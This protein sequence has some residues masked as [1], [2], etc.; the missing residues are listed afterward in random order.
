MHA[1]SIL[2]PRPALPL[3][4]TPTTRSRPAPFSPAPTTHRTSTDSWTSANSSTV[5]ELAVPWSADDERFLTRT[6]DHLPAHLTTPFLGPVPPGNLLHRIARGV[7]DA[8][9]GD[10]KNTWPHSVRATRVKLMQLAR[11]RAL[12]DEPDSPGQVL[13]QST[14]ANPHTQHRKGRL[15]RQNSMDFM[16]PA[17]SKLDRDLRSNDTIAKL[18]SRLQKHERTLLHPHPYQY[19][20]SLTPS[21]PSSSTLNSRRGLGIGASPYARLSASSAS[22]FGSPITAPRRPSSLRRASTVTLNSTSEMDVDIRHSAE[23]TSEK[24]RGKLKRA[25]SFGAGIPSTPSRIPRSTLPT[26]INTND[27]TTTRNAPATDATPLTPNTK[28]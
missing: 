3:P 9:A 7:V 4:S 24:E 21:T 2:S 19:H 25:P 15:Y 26:N 11:E 17:V 18:S 6:L 16:S 27:T 1:L 14:N 23:F 5:D 20:R 8:K 22:S 13:A 28:S 10:D 12:P